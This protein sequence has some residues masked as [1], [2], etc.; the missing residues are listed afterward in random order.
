MGRV[1]DAQAFLAKELGMEIT[2]ETKWDSLTTMNLTFFLEESGPRLTEEQIAS[3][4]SWPAVRRFLE[5]PIYKVLVLDAD[6]TLWAG[7]AGEGRVVAFP[8]VQRVFQDLQ[9]RGVILCMA[10]RNDRADIDRAFTTERM[11]LT[12]DDFTIMEC[13]WHNK[14]ESI[15]RIATQLNIG[16]EAIVFV[17]DSEFE[18]EAVRQQLPEVRVVHAPSR[19]ALGVARQVAQLFPA[20]VD[21]DKTRQYH[22]LAQARQERQHFVTEEEFLRSLGIKMTIRA[23]RRV[24]AARIS[25]LTQKS[26]QFNLTTRRYSEK[27]IKAFIDSSDANVY[28]LTYRDRFGDQGI[29]GVIIVLTSGSYHQRID[30]FLLSCRIL[31]RGVEFAPW[32]FISNGCVNAEYIA[33]PKNAQVEG[34]WRKVGLD[35]IKDEDTRVLYEGHINSSCPD[36][37]EVK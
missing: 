9:K 27:D 4:T 21:T 6:N 36:W 23:N 22:A 33:T 13:G 35:I 12:P 24:D 10:T 2:D 34:F 14:T 31:G 5:Q 17:D 30:T 1:E 28:S 11:V 29:I 19:I 20:F 18:C 32:E 3:L 26:N 37:I 7:L 8:N 16:L 15:Q 25:E